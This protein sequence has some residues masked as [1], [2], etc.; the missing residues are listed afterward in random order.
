[1]PNGPI[2]EGIHEMSGG[3]LQ[4]LS[5]VEIL[6][7]VEKEDLIWSIISNILDIDMAESSAGFPPDI[8][9]AGSDAIEVSV[10]AR[11]GEVRLTFIVVIAQRVV[12]GSV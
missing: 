3:L 4:P 7:K 5:L 8:F 12:V 1:M 11:L 10:E 9:F 6:H 2:G